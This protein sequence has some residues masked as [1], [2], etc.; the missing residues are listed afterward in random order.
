LPA[1]AVQEL[2]VNFAWVFFAGAAE[3][4]QQWREPPNFWM[5]DVAIRLRPSPVW[6]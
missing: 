4:A 3:P 2:F 6:R 5:L 1:E